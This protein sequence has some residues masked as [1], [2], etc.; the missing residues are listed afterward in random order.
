MSYLVRFGM[1]GTSWHLGPM[2]SHRT[3]LKGAPKRKFSG[4]DPPFRNE[5]STSPRHLGFFGVDLLT[6]PGLEGPG[7]T[8]SRVVE[9]L[10]WEPRTPP[11]V[12]Y[13]DPNMAPTP[14]PTEPQQV[15]LEA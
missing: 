10:D 8:G 5:G 12:R 2:S 13:L 15:R 3:E 1:T 4:G 6:N 7:G 14:S 11:Q 9:I